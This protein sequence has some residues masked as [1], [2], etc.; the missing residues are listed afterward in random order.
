MKKILTSVFAAAAL[1]FGLASCS[2]DLHDKELGNPLNLDGYNLVGSMSGWDNSKALPI[3]NVTGVEFKYTV[4]FTA[5][6]SDEAFAFIPALGSWDGQIGGDQIIAGTGSDDGISYEKQDNGFGAFNGVL[7]G[8][9]SGSYYEMTID[10]SSGLIAVSAKEKVAPVPFYL[11][12][13]FL[14][15]GIVDTGWDAFNVD[16]LFNAPEV[17][18]A[19]GSCTYTISFTAAKADDYFAIVKKSDN[20]RYHGAIEVGKD[21]IELENTTDGMK[22]S[23]S[24]G[25]EAGKPYFLIVVTKPDGT[26]TG[27]LKL[28]NAINIIGVQIVNLDENDYPAGTK[29]SIGGEQIGWPSNWDA[30]AEGEVDANGVVT[31]KLA[32]PVKLYSTEGVKISILVR[33][34]AGWEKRIAKSYQADNGNG[35]FD[36]SDIKC[37]DTDYIIY[38]DL[39]GL[40]ANDD[41]EWK[42]VHPTYN[43]EVTG[44]PEAANGSKVFFTG[45]YNSWTKPG[46]AGTVEAT[47]ASGAVSTVISLPTVDGKLDVEGKFAAAGW[48]TPEV[49]G[50]AKDDGNVDNAKFSVTAWPQKITATYASTASTDKYACTW[51]VE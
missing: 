16:Y 19:D 28:A 36:I 4:N 10:S 32:A 25:I 39:A 9:K 33:P 26:V 34:A 6:G 37:D 13:Y 38:A 31:Y 30:G 18:P 42:L 23:S 51:K 41:V 45:S 17:S 12:G 40:A 48:S 3:T 24:T 1:L 5:S 22:S 14:K 49:A 44:L 35:S 29:M 27:Q 43:V 20:S 15:G 46:D 8:L 21:A 2:G 50:A 47:I 11:D 7:K